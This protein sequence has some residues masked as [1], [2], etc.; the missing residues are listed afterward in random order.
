MRY[1]MDKEF[2][3]CEDW[4]LYDVLPKILRVVALL[5]GRVF[6]GRPISRDEDWIASSIN[7]TLDVVAA[8]EGILKVPR[9]AR[10]FMAK[11]IPEVVGAR[12]HKKIGAKLLKPIV[13]KCMEKYQ[14]AEKWGEEEGDDFVDQQGTFISWLMKYTEEKKRGDPLVLASAQLNC[15]DFLFPTSSRSLSNICDY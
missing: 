15:M 2:G 6:V 1:G 10:F 3:P 14:N 13:E 4:T 8:R 5:S 12:Q 11:W 7:F 9:W